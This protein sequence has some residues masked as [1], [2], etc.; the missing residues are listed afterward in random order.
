MLRIVRLSL[1][2]MLVA[3]FGACT[4][5]PTNTEL[6]AT[7]PVGST[8]TTITPAMAA[9]TPASATATTTLNT[10][11]DQLLSAEPSDF[12][13]KPATRGCGK[14]LVVLIADYLQRH[15]TDPQAL[16]LWRRIISLGQPTMEHGAED[17]QSIDITWAFDGWAQAE[18]LALQLPSDLAATQPAALEMG[19]LTIIPTNLDGDDNQDYLLSATISG[20]TNKIGQLRW[21]RWQ[22]GAW[23]GEHVL[24]Y[25][26]DHEAFIKL[27]DVTGDAQ[28]ELFVHSSSC[29][30]A[31]SGRLYGWTW[32]AGMLKQLFPPWANT[33]DL[34]ITKT[35]ATLS[36]ASQAARYQ[37]DGQYLTPV[38]LALPS[39]PYS[40]TIGAQLRYA[41][42]LTLLGHFAQAIAQLEQAASQPD[43]STEYGHNQTLKDARPIALFR[44][45]A[46]HI[47]KHDSAAAQAAWNH[48][49]A[50]FPQSLAAA[51]V[52]DFNLT[53]FN[54]SISQWCELLAAE[55]PLI[56]E[57]YQRELLDKHPFNEFDWLP[58]CHPRLLLPLQAWTQA[59]PL[60]NQFAALGLPWQVFSEAYDL[61]GDG[62]NDPLGVV[63][64]LGIYTP[65][66][67]LSNE[68][69][70]QPLY[71]NQPWSSATA[72][73]NLTDPDYFFS[74]PNAVSITDLDADG[75]PEWLFEYGGYFSLLAWV[76][77]RFWKNE[78]SMQ[79]GTSFYTATISLAPQLDG[80]Q[81]LI[82]DY[83]PNAAGQQPE[84]NHVEYNLRA[85]T[86]IQQIPKPLDT[87]TSFGYQH[88][89]RS[90]ATAYVALFGNN[91]LALTLDI[92]SLVGDSPPSTWAQHEQRVLQAL[93]LEYNG[94]SAEAQ[95]LLNSV[96][97]ASEPTGWSRL[98]QQRR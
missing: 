30:S 86:L 11:A 7:A 92:V 88:S 26:N 90:I 2:I 53:S 83:V 49:V 12:C 54:G 56:M 66:V 59:V 74:R 15:P 29:G 23:V 69:G 34:S 79:Q 35:D 21:M 42:G 94:Q 31:C 16:A 97:N 61:N 38:E 20:S 46:I 76:E 52:Q 39:G 51:V 28:P 6:V 24:S 78:V 68:A 44:V 65:W 48:V 57:G 40:Q 14:P 89:D 17:P 70:Y 50:A 84:P 71:V 33:S 27:G 8:T 36:I 67:M 98:V 60:A 37:F 32:R 22:Q 3:V 63:D 96:A 1:L 91:D 58:L 10:T 25:A 45:G 47:L 75:S 4:P 73:T 43:G 80:T 18:F 82:A 72:L 77:Q 19:K 62:L 41:H 55:R 85:G 87:S 93:A 5:T 81:R 13:S 9:A 64:W 95:R